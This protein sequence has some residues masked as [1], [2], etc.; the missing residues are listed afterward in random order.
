VV[1]RDA[2]LEPRSVQVLEPRAHVVERDAEALPFADASF[3]T[4]VSMLGAM[5]AGHPQ[6][7]A[8]EM[9]RVT[10]SGGR[11]ALAT[12]VPDGFIGRMLKLTVGYVPSPA[13][14]RFERR[15]MVFDYPIGPEETGARFR[16]WYGPGTGTTA[17]GPRPRA[18]R[19]RW[20]WY[21]RRSSG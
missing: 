3:D 11:I 19:R 13:G 18:S 5:F 1:R 20:A 6:L 2:E 8:E 17:P 9:L 4:V 15:T 16:A 7:A 21:G 14:V 12:W 10:R